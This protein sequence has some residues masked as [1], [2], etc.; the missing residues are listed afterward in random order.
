MSGLN[1]RAFSSSFFCLSRKLVAIEDTAQ[2]EVGLG[3]AIIQLHGFA[4]V[5]MGLFGV[6]SSF[7]SR[8]AW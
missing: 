5:L 3:M 4:V 6:V 1:N 8:P 2:L 7:E